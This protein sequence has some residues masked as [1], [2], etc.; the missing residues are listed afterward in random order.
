MLDGEDVGTA[1]S[2]E[3]AELFVG[4]AADT[5]WVELLEGALPKMLGKARASRLVV[6]RI[7]TENKC[8]FKDSCEE[9]KEIL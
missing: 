7:K 2:L 9:N 5:Q 4:V 1:E 6:T 8:M 3:E